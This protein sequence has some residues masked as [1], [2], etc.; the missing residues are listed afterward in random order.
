MAPSVIASVATTMMAFA[1]L[2]FVAGIMGKIVIVMPMVIISMLF[3]S[4]VESI[5]I[6]PCHLAHR[7]SLIFRIF[8]VVFYIF[9]WLA[10]LSKWINRHANANLERFIDYVYRPTLRVVLANRSVFLAACVSALILVATLV[11]SGIVPFSFFPKIDSNTLVASIT[12]PDG[13]PEAVADRWTKQLED[14][15]WEVNREFERTGESVGLTSYR[16]VGSTVT[17]RARPGAA[18]SSGGASNSGSVEIELVDAAQRTITSSEVVARWRAKAG[19][20]PGAES[21]T[22]SAAAH[23]PGGSPIEF[24][25]TANRQGASHLDEAVERVKSALAELP[26]VFDVTDDSLPGKWEF[27]LRIKDRAH[28]HGSPCGRSGGNDPRHVLRPGSH[29]SAARSPRSQIDGPLSEAGSSFAGSFPADPGAH[30]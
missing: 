9:A 23:G 20:I 4:L 26:G 30:R 14:S 28:G 24:K 17:G 29:A 27:R 2:M 10:P 7:D 13:T 19:R 18:Q 25:L 22:F 3:V 5:T 1:P 15:F 21:L 12:F 11:R 6:L 8:H 16:V